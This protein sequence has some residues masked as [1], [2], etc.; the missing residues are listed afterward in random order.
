M[1]TAPSI[2]IGHT[3]VAVPPLGIGTGSFRGL[4]REVPDDEAIATIHHALD[5]GMTLVDTAPWYGALEAERIVGAALTTRRRDS[6]V[7]ATKAGLWNENGDGV[8]GVRR[9]Q[10]LWS[11]DASLKRLGVDHVDIL[12][13]HDPLSD[14]HP[15]ILDE[16]LPTFLDLRAQGVIGAIG[17]GTGDWRILDRLTRD[18]P[19][20]CVMLAGRYTLLEHE[21]LPLL[22]RLRDQ[23]VAVFSAGIYNSGIL[24]SGSTAGAKYNYG[25]APSHVRERVA[26]LARVCEAHG[27][28]LKAAAAQFVRAHPAIVSIILGVESVEQVDDNLAAF[29]VSIPA[30]FWEHL[31]AENL[32]PPD[33]PTPEPR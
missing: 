6:L 10:I 18:F 20:D 2:P 30:A 11:L 29:A 31:R 13:L 5:R 26:R 7:L 22:N 1:T 3:G 15:L 16:T 27:V 14:D 4:Y 12:H 28:P 33:A 19:F 25:D 32:I 17:C 9:D 8:H 21:A 23:G 24:A